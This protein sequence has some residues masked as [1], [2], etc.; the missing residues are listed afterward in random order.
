MD[1]CRAEAARELSGLRGKKL[2]A[3][4]RRRVRAV[5]EKYGMKFDR[6]K[7]KMAKPRLLRKAQ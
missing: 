5:E 2:A 3:E 7:G 4:L 1:R 6:Y